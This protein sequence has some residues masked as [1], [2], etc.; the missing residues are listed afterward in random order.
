MDKPTVKFLLLTAAALVLAGVLSWGLIN[1]KQVTGFSE[2]VLGSLPNAPTNESIGIGIIE[3]K[4]T[5]DEING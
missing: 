1:P 3:F 4:K 2:Y 5:E